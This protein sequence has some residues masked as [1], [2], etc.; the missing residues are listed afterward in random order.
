VSAVDL[1]TGEATP[2][3]AVEGSILAMAWLP[4]DVLAIVDGGTDGGNLYAVDL[5]D[6]TVRSLTSGIT[7]W[8]DSGMDV[9]PDGQWLALSATASDGWNLYLAS[10]D[11]GWRQLTTSGNASMPTW[12]P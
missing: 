6:L 7:V 3:L 2:L 11:G 8:P 5:A 9:S 10:I 1:A 12:A 4:G